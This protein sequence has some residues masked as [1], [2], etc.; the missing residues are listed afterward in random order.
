MIAMHRQQVDPTRRSTGLSICMATLLCAGC[1]ELP[2]FPHASIVDGPRVL[3]IVAEPPE[4]TPGR[5]VTLSVLVADAEQ[6][7]VEYDVCGLIDSAFGGGAQYGEQNADDCTG[8][9]ALLHGS[10]PTWTIAGDATAPLAENRELLQAVLGRALPTGTL[11][12]VFEQVGIPVIVQATVHAD[13]QTIRAVKRVLLSEN[14]TPNLNPPPPAL[15]VHEAM[16]DV[17][18]HLEADPSQ[19]WSCRTENGEALSVSVREKLTLT[20]LVD[21]QTN[22]EDWVEQYNVLNARGQLERRTERAYYSWFAT[23]GRFAR[24]VTRAPLRN[25]VWTAPDTAGEQRLWV[26]VRD[27]HGGASACGLAVTV[28]DAASR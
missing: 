5:D 28:R 18:R 2:S 24:D 13:G 22:E 11:D 17:D 16:S 10:G 1:I 7:E 26:V 23:A 14:P 3:A 4:I 15:G 21:E 8:Q 20:P 12:R 6:V 19:P 27:G 9:T 25:Q